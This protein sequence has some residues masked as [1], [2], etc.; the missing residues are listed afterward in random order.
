MLK[1][2]QQ[3]I[4]NEDKKWAGIFLGVGGGKSLLALTLAQGKILIIV[5]KTLRDQKA[6][7]KEAEKFGIDKDITVISK[8]DFKK[9]YNTLGYY[10]TVI[11][12]EAKAFFGATTQTYQRNYV[13][14]IKTSQNFALM[15]EYLAKY[16]PERFYAC[17]GTPARFPM[18]VWA[19]GTL[20]GK[21]WDPFKFRQTFY[22]QG[23]TGYKNIWFPKKDKATEERLANL[24][25]SLGYTGQI[26]DWVYVPE[27]IDKVIYVPVSI[28]I[29]KRRTEI[30][31][32]EPDPMLRNMKIRQVEN[33]IEYTDTVISQNGVDTMV[34][35]VRLYRD[36][37]IST[38]IE[39]YKKYKKLLVFV[40]YTAQIER[41]Y[42]A[43]TESGIDCRLLTG[44]TKDRKE[45]IEWAQSMKEG[46]LFAQ[47]SLSSGY[48]L[49]NIDTVVFASKSY[50]FDDYVQARGRVQRI[51]NVKQNTYVHLLIAGGSDEKCHKAILQ[52]ENFQ[53][54]IMSQE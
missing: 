11:I 17:T 40:N 38:I 25:K 31:A 24:I 5:P 1:P 36:E 32:N 46:I 30:Y 29:E 22:V 9:Y 15:R 45:V 20:F 47:A 43:C 50:K 52:G 7:E 54:R 35:T 41:Y 28:E 13:Q 8:E 42:K 10:D 19:I 14:Y 12:D 44:K 18:N 23:G 26:S 2:H 39:L 34:K 48:N 16:R 53:E 3:H 21:V 27:Q 33:G 6:W 4:V 49:Q 37:K 51:D